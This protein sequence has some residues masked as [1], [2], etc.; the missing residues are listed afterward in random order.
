MLARSFQSSSGRWVLVTLL[1]KRLDWPRRYRG[2]GQGGVFESSTGGR[3]RLDAAVSEAF[4]GESHGVVDA[5][6]VR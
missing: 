1:G 4:G 2:L 6:R 5:P 3:H